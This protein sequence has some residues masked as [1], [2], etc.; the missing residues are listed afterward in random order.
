MRYL[1]TM[2]AALA[3]AGCSLGNDLG[4]TDKAVADFHSQL[5]AGN[6]SAIES[7]AGPEMKGGG[8]DFL[9]LLGRVHGQMGKVK[10]TNRTGFNDNVNNGVHTVEVTYTT[11][12][13][14]GSSEEKFIFR[15]NNGTTQMIYYEIKPSGSPS[16]EPSGS[17]SV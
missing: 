5:D 4:A 17:P 2:A 3:L 6:F 13:E 14:Q 12:F 9:G 8:Q 15:M 11:V 16:P 10:S 7:Q 1:I